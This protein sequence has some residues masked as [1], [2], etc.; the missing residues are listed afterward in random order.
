MEEIKYQKK[1]E[2]NLKTTIEWAS[3]KFGSFPSFT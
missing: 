3:V 1:E 2:L